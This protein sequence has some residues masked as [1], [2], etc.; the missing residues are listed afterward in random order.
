MPVSFIEANATEIFNVTQ[1]PEGHPAPNMNLRL[2]CSK[3]T[4]FGGAGL[5]LMA[6]RHEPEGLRIVYLGSFAGTKQCQC[7]GDVRKERWAKHI[8]TATLLLKRLSMPNERRYRDLKSKALLFYRETDQF[9]RILDSSFI[10]VNEEFLASNVFRSS[11]LEVSEKRLSFAIQNLL[12]TNDINPHSIEMLRRVVSFFNFY[13]WRLDSGNYANLKKRLQIVEK[14]IISDY[15][16]CLPMNKEYD[17]NAKANFNFFHYN[18][19]SLVEHRSKQF[20]DLSKKIRLAL[21]QEFV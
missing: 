12:R 16:S 14:S 17:D 6:Y 8:G 2:H 19:A 1:D 3:D 9:R 18:P 4:R 10:G 15:K 21:E 7:G 20:D 5:Y 13:Y 11:G